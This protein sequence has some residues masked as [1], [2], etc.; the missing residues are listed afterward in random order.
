MCGVFV[1]FA[2]HLSKVRG[3]GAGALQRAGVKRLRDKKRRNTALPPLLFSFISAG[4]GGSS[5]LTFGR[6]AVT[7]QQI[8]LSRSDRKQCGS[9]LSL[10]SLVIP[11]LFFNSTK[12]CECRVT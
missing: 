11:T 6:Q 3:A 12:G 2:K 8:Q 4:S 9:S 1:F 7:T 5:A 10:Q